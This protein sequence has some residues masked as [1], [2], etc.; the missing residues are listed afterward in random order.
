MKHLHV[1]VDEDKLSKIEQILSDNE[2]VYE[3]KTPSDGIPEWHKNKLL[4]RLNNPDPGTGIPWEEVDREMRKMLDE[5][6]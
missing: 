3:I 2:V 6:F 1:Y 5:E 4:E